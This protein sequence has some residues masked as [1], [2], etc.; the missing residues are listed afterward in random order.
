[1]LGGLN[2][3][4]FMSTQTEEEKPKEAA[5]KYNPFDVVFGRRKSWTAYWAALFLI[6]GVIGIVLAL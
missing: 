1:M 4:Q 6:A 3:T 5:D 2:I